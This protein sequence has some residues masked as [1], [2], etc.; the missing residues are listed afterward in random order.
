MALG[1]RGKD[2]LTMLLWQGLKPVAAGGAIGMLLACAAANLIRAMLYG[3][4][5]FD[6]LALISTEAI[7]LGMAALAALIPARSA[8]RVDP[9]ITLR[10]D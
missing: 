10:H 4:S 6:P 7:L 1:A 2:V 3:I 9:A 5:P 8:M